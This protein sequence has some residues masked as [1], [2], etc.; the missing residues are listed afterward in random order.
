MT[1]GDWEFDLWRT[2]TGT[3]YP[4]ALGFFTLASTPYSRSSER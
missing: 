1:A 4:V 2:D 3:K